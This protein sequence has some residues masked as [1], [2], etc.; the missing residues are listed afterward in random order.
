MSHQ[1]AFYGDASF[2]RFVGTS[3]SEALSPKLAVLGFFLGLGLEG[4][5]GLGPYINPQ[6]WHLYSCDKGIGFRVYSLP[7]RQGSTG[8]P[9]P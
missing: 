3:L 6:Q 1:C 7:G 4:V 2:C 9:G 8:K 5:Q